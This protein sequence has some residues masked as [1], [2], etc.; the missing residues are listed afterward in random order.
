M[1]SNREK[2][3]W[4][5]LQDH[6]KIWSK[7]IKSNNFSYCDDGR[8]III[9]GAIEKR[10]YEWIYKT[11]TKYEAKRIRATTFVIANLEEW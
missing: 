9:W 4:I 3:F 8:A 1:G 2:K 10:R 5:N 11:T 6:Y 7:E